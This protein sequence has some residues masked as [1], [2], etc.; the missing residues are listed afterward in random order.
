MSL[1]GFRPLRVKREIVG[2][3]VSAG[4]HVV[5]PV[6]RVKGV[7]FHAEG[8]HGLGGGGWL[9]VTPVKAVVRDAAGAERT[10]DLPEV[11][12][13]V[14][15]RLV[16]TSVLLAAGALLASLVLRRRSGAH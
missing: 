5:Q 6:A 14:V 12:G 7:L 2:E 10:V 13:Q 9:Q 8:E 4:N 15:R 11:N 3:P 1:Q 16:T